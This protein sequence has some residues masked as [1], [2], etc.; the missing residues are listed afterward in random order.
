MIRLAENTDKKGLIILWQEAFGDSAESVEF[1][2]NRRFTPHNTVVAEENGRIVSMLYLLEGKVACSNEIYN[3]YYLYAAATLKSHRGRGLMALMLDY[4]KNIAYERDIDLICLKPADDGL[5]EYYGRYGYKPV[6]A[7]QTAIISK[8][9]TICNNSIVAE[10]CTDYFSA[11]EINFKN[12]DRFIWDKSAIEFALD[13]H[14]FFGGKVFEACNGYCLYSL[15]DDFCYVKEFCF[16]QKDFDIIF[17][18]I[19]T[20]N[21][22]I[23]VDLPV[24]FQLGSGN[25]HIRRNGMA[26]AV[27]DKGADIYDFNNLYLNLTL[28]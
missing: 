24:D 28:D 16:T 19:N 2:L 1:F 12:S 9:E 26:L 18:K 15:D 25:S 20:N 6:F 14:K 4:A 17:D 27:T 13:F 10:K 8:N 22:K 7:T 23:K 11:R 5:Y 21:A 3:A